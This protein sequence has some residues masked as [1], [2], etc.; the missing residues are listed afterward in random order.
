[1]VRNWSKKLIGYSLKTA[2]E[3]AGYSL[4]QVARRT[5]LRHDRLKNW[6]NGRSKPSSTEL[7]QLEHLYRSAV[8]S[9]VSHVARMQLRV[10]SLTDQIEAK[11]PKRFKEVGCEL[12]LQSLC[13]DTPDRCERVLKRLQ[14]RHWLSNQI[15]DLQSGE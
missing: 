7:L 13:D 12:F 14:N 2:R 9:F 5:G 4:E 1:M 8:P 3:S 6:E 11:L 15:E 10:V